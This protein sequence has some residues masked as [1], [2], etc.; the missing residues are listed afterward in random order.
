ML[1]GYNYCFWFAAAM[2]TANN[3]LVSSSATHPAGAVAK[4]ADPG[5]GTGH[6]PQW[7][8][9]HHPH[10]G[11]PWTTCLLSSFR[12]RAAVP[13]GDIYAFGI[14]LC[15]AS[16]TLAPWPSGS[17]STWGSSV[18]RWCCTDLRPL[19]P[20]QMPADL[21]L[22]MEHCWATEPATGPSAGPR[23]WSA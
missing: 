1:S 16:C 20:Q 4:V 17:C 12:K 6:G 14:M 8:S 13:A 7:N 19:V 3:V 9:P 15:C 23:W 21:R 5:S 18:R 11:L 22:L 2:Q 10:P